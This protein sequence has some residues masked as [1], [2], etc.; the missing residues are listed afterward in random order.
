VD[1]DDDSMVDNDQYTANNGLGSLDVCRSARRCVRG[2][3]G[4]CADLFAKGGKQKLL[5]AFFWIVQRTAW[6]KQGDVLGVHE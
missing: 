4:E 3:L 6:K 1:A 5:T 2:T